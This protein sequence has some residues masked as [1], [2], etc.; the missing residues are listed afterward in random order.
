MVFQRATVLMIYDR[1]ATLT[2]VEM[3]TAHNCQPKTTLRKEVR[4]K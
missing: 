4:R 1:I 3:F 2:K